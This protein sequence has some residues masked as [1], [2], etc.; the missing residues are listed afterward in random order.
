MKWESFKFFSVHFVL[1]FFSFFK[2]AESKLKYIWN[3]KKK[4]K[5]YLGLFHWACVVSSSHTHWVIT[6]KNPLKTILMYW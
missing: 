4:K 3:L 2:F 5:D 6:W 1:I